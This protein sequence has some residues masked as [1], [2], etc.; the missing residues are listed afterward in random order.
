MRILAIL[1]LATVCAQAQWLGPSNPPPSV[2][3][4]WD[5]A[6][7]NL[8]PITNYF[9]YY[10][11]GSRQY[12]VKLVVGLNLTL[13]VPNLTRGTMYYFA[14]T[15]QDANGMES[16]FSNEISWQPTY[17]PSP[18]RMKAPVVLTA[19]VKPSL[20]EGQW[21]TAADWTL[22]AAQAG[23]VF[24]LQIAKAD[25]PPARAMKVMSLPAREFPPIPGQ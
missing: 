2:K 14:A 9:L 11:Q 18:P 24:R 5:A 12:T 3:L 21:Q 20:K 4:A 16:D 6:T 7:N 17:V 10:G 25:T 23:G 19:Q 15:A 13:T 8:T 22:D 1:L